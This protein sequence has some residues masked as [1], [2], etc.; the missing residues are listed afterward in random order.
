M[1]AAESHN[2][3]NV[4]HQGHFARARLPLR[5]TAEDAAAAFVAPLG[6]HLEQTGAGKVDGARVIAG[7]SGEAE[8]LEIT[9]SMVS[10]APHHL[11]AVADR[12]EQ[13]DAPRGS[14]IGNAECP[15]I[16]RFGRCEGLGLY[17]SKGDTGPGYDWLEVAEA[18]TDAMAGLG[19]YQGARSLPDRTA[20]YFYGD[21]FSKMKGAI[22]F[23]LTTD[24]RCK[25]A[26]ARR[27]LTSESQET[28]AS[29]P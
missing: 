13:L 23:L 18:C 9:L 4:P 10:D 17:L 21:S 20:L 25:N 16:Y 29:A 11:K 7:D 27:L 19:I 5:I 15:D 1:I 14:V 6:H 8:W 2:A 12:L 3:P 28:L 26:Y 22:T 24:P